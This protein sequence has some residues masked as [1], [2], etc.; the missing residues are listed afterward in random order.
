[1]NEQSAILLVAASE[2]DANMYYA[3]GIFVPDPFIYVETAA[4]RIIV[5]GNLELDRA[6][7]FASV[8][9]VEPLAHYWKLAQEKYSKLPGTEEVVDVLLS[10]LGVAHALVPP[11]FSVKFADGIR[12]YGYTVEV[13]PEPFFEKRVSKTDKE[14]E[15]MA[16]T[17]RHTED[18]VQRAIEVIHKSEVSASGMLTVGN[19]PLTSEDVKKIIHRYLIEHDCVAQHTVVSCGE[20]TAVPHHEGQGP[21][22]AHEPIILDVSPKSLSN[23]YYADITRTVVR[24]RASESLRRQFDAVLE[25]QEY[26]IGLCQPNANGKEIHAAVAKR[27]DELGF[28]THTVG[29]RPQGFF[30]AAGHGLGL[31]GHER[32]RLALRDE[33]LT[34]GS[35]ITVEPGL[36]YTGIGG[37]RTEDVVLVTKGGPRVLT[38][39]EKTLEV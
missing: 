38:T 22:Y 12:K 15:A 39:L 23:G 30:H 36:Y 4:E 27:L 32:P 14:V 31:E 25:A 13:R 1:M 33:F 16:E 6:R 7:A 28:K 17:I 21:L 2:K 18:A 24:G 35:V 20:D 34:V 5:I 3:T 37:V 9:R 11:A 29:G 19:T 26:G 10:E 8:D